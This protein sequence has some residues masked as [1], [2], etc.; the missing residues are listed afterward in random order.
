MFRLGL[1]FESGLV[2]N[3]VAGSQEPALGAWDP[4][5]WGGDITFSN[6]NRT[7]STVDVA[8]GSGAGTL[9]HSS[10]KYAIEFTFI[11]GSDPVDVETSA[12][13]FGEGDLF[14]QIQA[15]GRIADETAT[16]TDLGIP[17]STGGKARIL[18]DLTAGKMWFGNESGFVGNPEAGTGA[19]YTFPSGTEFAPFG[20]VYSVDG[21][22][23]AIVTINPSYTSGTFQAWNS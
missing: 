23:A 7:A 18:V 8:G 22:T 15:D 16:Y 9:P 2:S 13:L 17:I 10:G 12:G 20:G 6:G 4:L 1:G 14:A 21:I 3:G 5:T 19:S 11:Y